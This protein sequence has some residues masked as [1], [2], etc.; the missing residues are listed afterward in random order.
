MKHSAVTAGTRR[1]RLLIKSSL[2]PTQRAYITPS[3]LTGACEV[4]V[5]GLFLYSIFSRVV[6]DWHEYI[7]MC[8][9]IKLGIMKGGGFVVQIVLAK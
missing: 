4:R 9:Y 1:Q 2:R 5:D 3:T 7:K 6:L 8:C